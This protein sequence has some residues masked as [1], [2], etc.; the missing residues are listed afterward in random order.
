MSALKGKADIE[1]TFG[2][3]RHLTALAQPVHRLM[4]PKAA[5]FEIADLKDRRRN[6][7]S[8]SISHEQWPADILAEEF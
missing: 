4:L 6:F 7:Q 2:N 1:R 5:Q 3:G 8:E